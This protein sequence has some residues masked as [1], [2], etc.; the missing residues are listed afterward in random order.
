MRSPFAKAAR[1]LVRV[2][3][4]VVLTTPGNAADVARGKDLSQTHCARCH[5]VGDFNPSGGISSTPSFQLLAKRRPDYRDRFLTFYA[6]RPHPAFVIVEGIE[7]LMPELPVNA[8]P[9]KLS[10]E[11]V[12]AI[13]AFAET[14]KPQP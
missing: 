14:L 10:L 4:L 9:V 12:D 2:S 3:C 8:E 5:V 1:L 6:R 11:D 13:V 7:R